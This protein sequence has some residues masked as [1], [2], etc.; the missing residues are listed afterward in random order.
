MRSNKYLTRFLAA[1]AVF[2]LVLNLTALPAWAVD[3]SAG[4][5]KTGNTD[6]SVTFTA[7]E[8]TLSNVPSL[9]FGSH[10]ISNQE[11][12]Y[13]AELMGDNIR[14]SDLR[15]SGNGWKLMVSLSSFQLEGGTLP[16]L[17]AA[18]IQV[19][20]Q[21]VSAANG[22]LGKEPAAVSPLVIPSDSTETL[23]WEAKIDEGMG[24]WELIWEAADVKL[25]VK[26]GTGQV[27]KSVATMDWNLQTAP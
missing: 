1:A 3:E 7:G 6:V 5:G 19:A 2:S 18:S 26:P 25:N 4:A 12:N 14:V 13:S 15:G 24:V 22:T 8:L 27:G 11:E 17:K 10:N 23:V 21:V 9:N 20:N 16:T